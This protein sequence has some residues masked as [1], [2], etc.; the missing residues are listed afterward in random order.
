MNTIR[1]NCSKRKY[2]NE[3]SSLSVTKTL[4][5]LKQLQENGNLHH[6][7]QL[8]ESSRKKVAQAEHTIIVEKDQTI[9]TT[10]EN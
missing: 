4:F 6:F 8:I 10:L 9:I 7:S 5:G 1:F 3:E 2:G